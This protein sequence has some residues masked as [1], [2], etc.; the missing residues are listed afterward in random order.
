MPPTKKKSA[1]DKS[2]TTK[3]L[4]LFDHIKH[5]RTVQS[6]DY[7]KKLSDSEKKSFNHFM[8]LKGLSMDPSVVEEMA[9]LYKLIDKVPSEQ[10]YKL[11]IE[12]VPPN[13]KFFPWIKGK[14]QNYSENAIDVI[15]KKFQISTDESKAYFDILCKTDDGICFIKDTMRSFGFDEKQIEKEKIS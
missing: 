5:I 2:Q 15:S 11:L 8:I 1:K 3:E 10:F 14:K 7:F 12:I 4:G 13:N 9:Y 6:P